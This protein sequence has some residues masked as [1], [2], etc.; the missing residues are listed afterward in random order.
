[1]ISQNLRRWL[2]DRINVEQVSVSSE[3]G[4]ESTIQ[5]DITYVVKNGNVRQRI[6][7]RAP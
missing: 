1:V 2:G 3:P 6:G 5:I 4:D 7:V